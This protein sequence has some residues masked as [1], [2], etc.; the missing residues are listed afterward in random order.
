MNT[1]DKCFEELS[2]SLIIPAYNETERL[3]EVLETV[4]KLPK[5]WEKIVVSDGSTDR[6]ADVARKFEVKVVDLEENRGKA[7][8]MFE[9]FKVSKGEFVMFLDADLIRP[10]VGDIYNLLEPIKHGTADFAI[11]TF[12]S[13]RKEDRKVTRSHKLF[14]FIGGQQVTTRKKWEE[15]FNFAEPVIEDLRLG[16]ENFIKRY[17]YQ[18]LGWRFVFVKWYDVSQNMK[19]K[20]FGFWLGLKQRLKM[21]KEIRRAKRL[22]KI[23][24]E[25]KGKELLKEKARV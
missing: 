14:P 15:I 22:L 6:T 5:K 4:K 7:A 8:A 17:C 24:Y 13:D 21:Y 9:G 11:A 25:C 12:R 3:P 18:N 10:K 16:I 1:K 20:K 2:V 23:C 19:E